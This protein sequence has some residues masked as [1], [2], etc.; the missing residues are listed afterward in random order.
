[1]VEVRCTMCGELFDIPETEKSGN[2]PHCGFNKKLTWVR[3]SQ[4]ENEFGVLT[5]CKAHCPNCGYIHDCAEIE[6]I[7]G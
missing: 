2:C 4:C 7:S 1:M 6:M 5:R 3:C